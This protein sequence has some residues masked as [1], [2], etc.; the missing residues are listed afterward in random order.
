MVRAASI[1]DWSNTFMHL[2]VHDELDFSAPKGT[3]E[4]FMT[5]VHEAMED[6]TEAD[7]PALHV[8]IKADIKAGASWGALIKADPDEEPPSAALLAAI[9]V[10]EE[11][12]AA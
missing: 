8:P 10:A 7:G 4:G 12:G 6:W 5:Q 9:R 11:A 2:S 3:E 1:V